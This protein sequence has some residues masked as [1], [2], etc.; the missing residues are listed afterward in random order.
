MPPRKPP[1]IPTPDALGHTDHD[2]YY[3]V[4]KPVTTPP[5]INWLAVLDELVTPL[6][7]S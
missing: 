4:A 3:R 5:E 6:L 7:R 1:F 2:N